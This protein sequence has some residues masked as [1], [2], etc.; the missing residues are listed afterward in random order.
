M[1]RGPGVVGAGWND[2][3]SEIGRWRDA[4]RIVEFWWRDDDATQPTSAL[5]RLLRLARQFKVPLA[6]A[7][8]PAHA[9]PALFALLPAEAEVLQHGAD[10]SNRATPRDKKTEYPAN[11]A[12]DAALARLADG[13]QCL[14]DLA[15]ARSLG[16]LA[17]P[18]N[19]IAPGLLPRL[20][21]CGFRGL[22]RYGARSSAQAAPGVTEINTHVDIIDWKGSRG[23]IGVEQALSQATRHLAARRQGAADAEEPTGWLTHHAC[24]D[25]EAWAF[26]AELF[27]RLRSEPG[28]RWKSARDLFAGP[29]AAEP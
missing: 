18:W 21:S 3:A 19:R 14:S 15:G 6:L 10:H 24:H 28:A 2:L 11:E 23:F 25:E 12:M 26:L 20:A 1:D 16:V 29:V 7:V 13:R 9:D 17:P 22:S 5:E 8:I 27:D 4:G